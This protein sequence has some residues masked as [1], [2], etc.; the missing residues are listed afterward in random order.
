MTTKLAR[1]MSALTLATTT[2]LMAS[3][4]QAAVTLPF[5]ENFN[6]G[7][8]PDVTFLDPGE[9]S[10]SG[11]QLTHSASVDK[12]ISSA[13][14][15]VSGSLTTTGIRMSS[16]I[17]VSS[18]PFNSD[19]GFAAFGA[20]AV[21]SL[22]GNDDH[23]LADFKANGSM[24]ILRITGAGPLVVQTIA[25]AASGTFSFSLGEIYELI[26]EVT[27]DGVGGFDMSLTIDDPSKAGPITISGNDPT[28]LTG[29]F[30][31]YRTRVSHNEG[32]LNVTFDD[33]ALTAMVPEPLSSAVLG[34][35]MLLMTGC[36]RQRR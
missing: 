13:T 4:G 20:S 3:P 15:E 27:P 9:W 5:S 10:I 16:L 36:Y 29:D 17:S 32:T 11:G 19:V 6:S 30:F 22:D 24:R 1:I 26:F 33:L 31:G 18:I 35:V 14:V 21:F 23:Y 8:A 7:S 34:A 25:S 28:P 12:N 2:V